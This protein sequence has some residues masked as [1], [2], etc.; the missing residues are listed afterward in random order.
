M[1]LARNSAE[2]VAVLNGHAD[3]AAWLERSGLWS[4][5]LHHL[6]IIGANR[7]RELLR[8][9]DRLDATGVGDGPTQCIMRQVGHRGVKQPR[10]TKR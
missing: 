3:L 8:S 4:T 1:D 5:P 9:G 6:E 7:A 10:R 2:A